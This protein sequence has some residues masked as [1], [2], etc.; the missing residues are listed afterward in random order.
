MATARKTVQ[1][2]CSDTPDGGVLMD[3]IRDALQQRRDGNLV[4]ENVRA[5]VADLAQSGQMT[6]LNQI[7]GVDYNDKAFSGQLI[8][9]RLG[10]DVPT[11]QDQQGEQTNQFNVAAH[12]TQGEKPIEG[13]LY[14]T[15]IGN[16]V[17]LI[18]SRAVRSRWLERYLTWLLKDK[19]NVIKG[20][21]VISLNASFE[22]EGAEYQLAEPKEMMIH[23]SSEPKRDAV[24]QFINQAEGKGGQVFKA[25]KALG[26]DDYGIS[27]IANRIPEGGTLEGDLKVYI[28]KGRL[29]EPMSIATIDHALRNIDSEDLAVSSGGEKLIKGLIKL[30]ATVDVECRES[31][32]DPDDAVVQIKRQMHTWSQNGKIDL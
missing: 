15:V 24:R 9:Y 19:G 21:D 25:L 16:H 6:V 17:G 18:G 5:R 2:R 27:E 20:E 4:G 23:I 10:M 12:Y 14:F 3:N 30:S 13:V 8:L 28:K 31:W 1:Y 32:L 22:L 29:K 26:F 7:S 11:L